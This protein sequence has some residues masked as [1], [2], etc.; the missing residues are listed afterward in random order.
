[1]AQALRVM[2][3]QRGIDP[4]ALTLVSFG[5]AGGLHVCALAEALDMREALVPV[6]AGV[7]S[8]LGMLVAPRSR[9]LSQTINQ[10]LQRCDAQSLETLYA[11]LI[12][13]GQRELLAEGVAPDGLQVVRSVDVRY[14]GQS[15]YLNVAWQDVAQ[16]ARA[17]HALHEQ[18][19]GHALDNPLEIV[20]VRVALFSEADKPVL[21]ATDAAQ[22]SSA[23]T[24]SLYGIDVPAQLWQREHIAVAETLTGP[25]LI[26]ETIST[27]YLAPGWQASK[28]AYGNLLLTR[29]VQQD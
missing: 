1:M 19:Y 5:G 28:D 22:V 2:S 17:F 25:A 15:Y 26:T 7:L 24:I 13:E 14:Q 16:T 21:R 20:N 29:Q 10:L 23:Q 27:T 9:Q 11:P 18:R 4:R 12:E 8:A 3:V 6:H